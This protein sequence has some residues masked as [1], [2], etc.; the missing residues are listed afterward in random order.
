LV[1]ETSGPSRTAPVRELFDPPAGYRLGA[2]FLVTY[3]LSV[4]ALVDLVLAPLARAAPHEI[5]EIA[6]ANPLL[7]VAYERL[8][9]GPQVPSWNVD[10]VRPDTTE[11]RPLH[12]KGGLLRFEP[13]DGRR[14][15][16][17]RGWVGSANLTVGGLR[18]NREVLLVGECGLAAP[19]PAVDQAAQ[20]CI[21]VATACGSLAQRRLRTV[22]KNSDRA[23]RRR[24]G[25]LLHTVGSSRRLLDGTPRPPGFHRLDIVSPVYQAARTGQRVAEHLA[26]ILPEGGEVHIYSS[27]NLIDIQP[28]GH[29]TATFP[30]TLV[31]HLRGHYGLEVTVH[32]LPE[33]HEQRRRRLHAK[34]YVLHGDHESVV[35]VGSA[36]ATVSGLGGANREAL[37]TYRVPSAAARQFIDEQLTEH[38]WT[39]LDLD[40][41]DLLAQDRGRA[42]GHNDMAGAYAVFRVADD[43]PVSPDGRWIGD[44]IL[45]G[46]PAGKRYQVT[47]GG[48]TIE[49]TSD[50]EG[51]IDVTAALAERLELLPRDGVVRISP[52]D[53]RSSEVVVYVRASEACLRA[54]IEQRDRP[55]R[56][57]S[58][59]EIHE[60]ERLLASIRRS[61][62]PSSRKPSARD[63]ASALPDDRLTLPLDRRFD[64][65]AKFAA[66]VPWASDE[67]LR[68][69][70]DVDPTDARV[71]V[72]T[73][74]RTA[75]TRRAPDDDALLGQL[76]RVVRELDGRRR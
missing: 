10:L 54:V 32:I 38:S 63:E 16:L 57:R 70:L 73:A 6:L 20:L 45:E 33:L 49:A 8:H 64:L 74:I 25:G 59:K 14:R 62:R 43:G 67:D 68:R 11:E 30:R 1:V 9:P 41:S 2:G 24:R 19:D 69:F 51:R 28:G 37:A 27:T 7:T 5:P 55:P 48:R 56:P 60:L 12:A 65:V 29:H 50:A 13:D 66:Q 42:L 71:A 53:E 18:H 72:L 47:I 58:P 34:A 17:L 26:P 15:V 36:N 31:D 61:S 4:E 39:G 76:Q 52:T 3:D 40:E 35:L 46:L 21:E 75:R 44:L 23:G 22:L